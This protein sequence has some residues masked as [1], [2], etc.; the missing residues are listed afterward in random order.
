M[1]SVALI[2]NIFETNAEDFERLNNKQ[3]E[4][5]NNKMVKYS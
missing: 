1:L 2:W 4:E 5:R 3:N